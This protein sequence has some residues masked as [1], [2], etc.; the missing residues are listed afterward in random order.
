MKSRF[1]LL[2][3]FVYLLVSAQSYK[4]FPTSDA[5]WKIGR[6]WYF[7]PGGWYDELTVNMPGE[8][9]VLNSVTYKKLYITHR[10]IHGAIDS[11]YTR[12][13]GGM[14]ESDR[15]IFVVSEEFCLDT[16]E[17]MVYDFG[18]YGV[19][20]TI[21]TNV[22]TNGTLSKVPHVVTAIDS[23]EV[24]AGWHRRLHLSDTSGFI[25]EAWIEGVGSNFGL[26]YA[27]YWT[28][29]DNSYDLVC[30]N[31]LGGLKYQNPNPGYGFCSSPYPEIGC[32][33]G[34]L[35]PGGCTAAFTYSKQTD[36]VSFTGSSNHANTVS[37]Q[38]EFGDGATAANQNPQH[39]YLQR[40]WY[41]A[42]LTVVGTDSTGANCAATVCDSLYISD[43]CID[44]SLICPP[45]SLCCDA[46]LYQ[47]VCGCDS[48]TYD[49]GCIAPL[50]HGVLHFTEG[51]C[52]TSLHTVNGMIRSIALLPNPA[53]EYMLLRMDVAEAGNLRIAVKNVLGETQFVEEQKISNRGSYAIDLNL[54][55]IL[56]GI[57]FVE[58][59]LNE[60]KT[61]KKFVRE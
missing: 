39:I 33:T 16:L 9:T 27:T 55:N 5:S 43:G 10:L 21:R 3:S 40:G 58:V 41:E 47:P 18:E 4:P 24:G 51:P 61:V 35:P 6:C 34:T 56:K 60:N 7:F 50:W 29:T 14:R 13:L 38:W 53:G 59:A 28:I 26:P 52:L 11:G 23:V 12:Y 45:G 8:D 20:D 22:L 15:E 57:Y 42:C 31:H 48:V 49:N 2:F 17:R 30:F 36:T 46:P 37:W 25:S 19:G 1:T 44:S 32:D 54:K